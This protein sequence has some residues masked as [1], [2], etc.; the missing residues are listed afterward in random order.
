[1]RRVAAVLTLLALLKGAAAAPAPPRTVQD[2]TGREAT[3]PARPARIVSLCLPATDTLLRLGLSGRLAGIDEFGACAPG[4]A[5]IPV[6]ARG[7]TVSIERI[8][9]AGTDLV[10]VWW[11]QEEAARLLGAH[12]VPVVRLRSP[13]A[14][15]VP[16]AIRLVGECAGESRA[17]AALAQPVEDFLATCAP[18]T[19]GPAVFLE[20][21]GA[22]KTAG[23]GTFLDDLLALAGARNIAAMR[24]GHVVLSAEAVA[25]AD[26]AVALLAGAR[27]EDFVRRPGMAGTSAARA[28]R[29]WTLDRGLTI[30]GAG[31]PESV[32]RLRT[33]L[34][35]PG[36]SRETRHA[37][38]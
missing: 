28:G 2:M 1:M 6:I 23:H 26:P 10:F 14:A 15:E 33:L 25:A 35:N 37:V 20:L 16:A 8:V 4:A 11:Y 27:P 34:G 19:N 32:A 29:V 3:L 30:A 12:G 5:G 24:E 7:G 36:P 31:L 18:S 21:Y 22:F 13:R 38:P 17:A 9:G